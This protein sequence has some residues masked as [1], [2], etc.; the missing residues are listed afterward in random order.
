MATQHP[1]LAFF[2]HHKCATKFILAILKLVCRDCGLNVLTV[3]SAKQVDGDLRTL[4]AESRADVLA[5]MNAQW[6]HAERLE[7]F[8]GFHIIRDPRDVLVS[9]YFSHLHSHET[10]D[11]DAL[12]AHRKSLQKLSK[13]DGLL[14]EMEF[15]APVFEAMRQWQYGHAH[16]LELRFEQLVA[17]PYQWFLR[18]FEH[19]GLIDD[20]NRRAARRLLF[21][22]QSTLNRG[23]RNGAGPIPWRWPVRWIPAERMLAH[24]YENRF[25]KRAGGR[26]R[27]EENVEHHFRK[28]VPGDWKNHFSN[29]H[30]RQFNRRYGDLLEMTGYAETVTAATI[31]A[32]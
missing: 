18:V 2:G 8:R 22:V 5:Y 23:Y 26:D 15:C 7:N 32:A 30:V 31:A 6:R 9:A 17:D 29:E 16:I 14:L 10:R 4:L 11:W 28:G 25:A 20:D 19:L 24:V 1:L 21:G 27:G 3:S 12:P 13:D